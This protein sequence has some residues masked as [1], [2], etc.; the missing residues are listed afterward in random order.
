M[1]A[2]L[3]HLLPS[4]AHPALDWLVTP[5]MIAAVSLLSLLLF[6]A[7]IVA[8]PWFV[9]RLP[10]DYFVRHDHDAPLSVIRNPGRRRLAHIAKNV[11]GGALLV[12]GL[13]MLVLPGQGVLTILMALVLLRF[14]GKRA[15]ERKLVSRPHV[16]K[17]LNSIRRR[18]G[19]DP[20]LL[21]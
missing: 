21:H 4:W 8:L 15:L 3:R 9:V 1:A 13:A 19:A 5:Q 10:R 20:L 12:A 16:L 17:A 11:L 6:I 14:P 7:S 2:W 18:A